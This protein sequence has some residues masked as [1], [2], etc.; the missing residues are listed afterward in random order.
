MSMDRCKLAAVLFADMVGYSARSQGIALE[1]RQEMMVLANECLTASQGRL[2]KT[3]GDEIFAEFSSGSAAINFATQLQEKVAVRNSRLPRSHRFLLRIGINAGEVTMEGEDL[4][5]GAVN[6]AKRAEQLAA[7]GG[8]CVTEPVRQQAEAGLQTGF[9]RL[10]MLSVKAD[11]P[12]Q[13]FFH[14]YDPQTSVSGWI[15]HQLKVRYPGLS[16]LAP[17][18]LVVLLLLTIGLRMVWAVE[19][20]DKLV[21]SGMKQ[22]ER[23][24]L[25]RNIDNAIRDLKKAR[26]FDPASAKALDG[27]AW[28]E[29]LQ[30]EDA[31]DSFLRGEAEKNAN[32]ALALNTNVIYA[33]VVLGLVSQERGDYKPAA[34]HLLRAN[35]HSRWQNGALIAR[36]ATATR[37]VGDRSQALDLAQRAE[38]KAGENWEAWHQLGVFW[39]GENDYSNSL[40]A[41]DRA[42]SIDPPSP[43]SAEQVNKILVS[44]GRQME[45]LDRAGQL[46]KKYENSPQAWS[47]YGSA[48]LLGNAYVPAYQAFKRAAELDSTNYLYWGNAGIALFMAQTNASE[49]TQ[50]LKDEAVAQARAILNDAPGNLQV[51]TQLAT[52]EVALEEQSS[53][54]EPF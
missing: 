12:K 45:A 6:V 32:N 26:K 11:P 8:I 51:R 43:K 20:P 49:W 14:R 30:Y 27:L 18:V 48:L 3:L 34:G 10:G 22:I 38:A 28:A 15:A 29:W 31:G 46:L 52:Y 47:V 17:P 24:D 35:D 41:F 7:P 9:I 21:S 50:I 33:D 40:R 42:G 44:T 23:F 5:G 1:L 25:P 4:I 54:L 39:F 16:R 37:L 36:L 19:D 2:I 13:I 53:G